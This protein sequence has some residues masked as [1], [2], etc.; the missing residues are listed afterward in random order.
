VR[1][2]TS[3]P[4]VE[5]LERLYQVVLVPLDQWVLQVMIHQPVLQEILAPP[6]PLGNQVLL[7]VIHQPGLLDPRTF[8]STQ[9]YAIQNITGSYTGNSCVSNFGANGIG[10]LF[11]NGSNGDSGATYLPGNDSNAQWQ[12]IG[13][14]ASRSVN[15][16]TETR[17]TNIA[18]Q[19]CIKL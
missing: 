5:F 4:V 1:L 7:E 13:F 3:K 19:I 2:K 14:D 15:T 18:F 10:A 17:P 9:A 16:S 6:V 8:G 12:S 11:S